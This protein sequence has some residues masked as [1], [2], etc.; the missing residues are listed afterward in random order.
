MK[1][2]VVQCSDMLVSYLLTGFHER[3]PEPLFD[4]DHLIQIDKRMGSV[5]KCVARMG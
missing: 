1:C 4:E 2:N 5:E 3:G